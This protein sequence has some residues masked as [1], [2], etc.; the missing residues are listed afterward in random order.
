MWTRVRGFIPWRTVDLSLQALRTIWLA[1][2]R[3]DGRP[4]AAP[5]WF[6]WVDYAVYFASQ[7]DTQKVRNIE[8][9]PSVV[10][11]A[12]DG[13]DVILLTGTAVVVTDRDETARVE[14]VYAAKYVDPHTGTRASV[15]DEAGH[16]YRIDLQRVTAWSYG[17]VDTRTDWRR[18]TFDPARP[19][20]RRR[21]TSCPPG[22]PITT[23]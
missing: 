1:T 21:T 17:I 23:E 7:R 16:L 3:P 22:S 20:I 11:H 5:V 13:D 14:I 19:R 9:Q 18:S 8:L 4:H 10:A 12:G 2:T 15:H 6:V